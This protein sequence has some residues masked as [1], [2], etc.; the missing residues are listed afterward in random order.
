MELCL[1]VLPKTGWCNRNCSTEKYWKATT[2]IEATLNSRPLTY[3]NDVINYQV[4]I[5]PV[6]LL[7]V[8][9]K[10]RP[11]QIGEKYG[12]DYKIGFEFDSAQQ[13]LK[14]WKKGN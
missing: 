3:P 14:I 5:T 2:D 4:M 1:W 11:P 8:N 6:H 12:P 13:L 7:S 9:V 10:H